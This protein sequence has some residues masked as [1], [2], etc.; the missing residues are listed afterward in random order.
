[1]QLDKDHADP[2]V[3]C[4]A[5]G[6]TEEDQIKKLPR[7]RK[8]KDEAKSGKWLIYINKENAEK[9]WG[10]LKTATE[11]GSLGIGA[12]IFHPGIPSPRPIVV[13]CVYTYD[14]EDK[15][16]VYRVL[17]KLRELGFTGTLPYKTDE[18]TLRGEYGKGVTTY[19]DPLHPSSYYFKLASKLM[20]AKSLSPEEALKEVKDED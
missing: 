9:V 6:Y 11:D 8:V 13:A 3:R 17:K 15:E 12:K 20:R 14:Y 1:M 5:P 16:D 2:W 19:R 18:D 10:I 7:G 4:Y